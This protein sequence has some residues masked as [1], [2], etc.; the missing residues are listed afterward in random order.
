MNIRKS[1]SILLVISCISCATT[2]DKNIDNVQKNIDSVSTNQNAS[3]L[4]PGIEKLSRSR[5]AG[6]EVFLIENEISDPIFNKKFVYYTKGVQKLSQVISNLSR[7]IGKPIVAREVIAMESS[8]SSKASDSSSESVLDGIVN[9]EFKGTLRE[10][11]DRI[12]DQNDISWRYKNGR[13]EFFR[14]DSKVF[15]MSL[16]GGKKEITSSI[17]LEGVGEETGGGSVSVENEMNVNPWSSILRGISSILMTETKKESTADNESL[18]VNGKFGYAVANPDLGIITVTARPAY[19]ERISSYVDSINKRF[20]QNILID[21]RIFSVNVDDNFSAGFSLDALFEDLIIG[22]GLS[23]GKIAIQGPQILSPFSGTPGSVTIDS[24]Y[25]KESSGITSIASTVFEA[26]N[27]IGSASLQT[28]GQVL[29]INGQPAPFQVAN[30][31][32]YVSGV[33][34]TQ[35]EVGVT[36]S[37]ET[38]KKVVGFTA[39]F[40]PMI[41]GDNRI[42]L[43]YQ[44]QISSLVGL[45]QITQADGSMIQLPEVASQT[46]Q[47]QSFLQDGQTLMLF[48]FAQ[49]RNSST[50]SVGLFGAS[51]NGLQEKQ[52][53]CIMLHIRSTGF[54][55]FAANAE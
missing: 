22:N 5:I 18:S 9:I 12:G 54:N 15:Y 32:N 34:Q 24:N 38:E 26:L 20:A 16:P 28:Q 13:I 48:S 23:L 31:I 42:L 43:Q 52:L 8:S 10:L 49:D 4:T 14:Y 47:Q 27:Q 37:T 1:L 17:S 35:S 46:L 3:K 44:M 19:L 41:L 33:T 21:I 36:S 53:L 55:G 6:E 50:G 40:L 29:A 39:N 11:L 30:E 51:K 7:M 2:F 25:N 45:T